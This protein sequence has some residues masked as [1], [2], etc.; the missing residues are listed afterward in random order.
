MSHI[1]AYILKKSYYDLL[2][3]IEHVL[4]NIVSKNINK[5]IINMNIQSVLIKNVMYHH[6]SKQYS[7]IRNSYTSRN[8]LSIIHKIESLYMDLRSKFQIW[9]I[10][11]MTNYMILYIIHN[12]KK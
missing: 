1:W 6:V 10:R 11:T 2:L 12:N 9:V 8:V 7:Y 3:K 4:Q 5:Y